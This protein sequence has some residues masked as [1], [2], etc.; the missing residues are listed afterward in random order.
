MK[1]DVELRISGTIEVKNIEDLTVDMWK[2]FDKQFGD[3]VF[4]NDD[5]E[6]KFVTVKETD[7]GKQVDM[8]A[9]VYKFRQKWKAK[10]KKIGDR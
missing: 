1:Y 3:S 10:Q 5:S 7:T 4:A 9:L 2:Y 6:L 8:K